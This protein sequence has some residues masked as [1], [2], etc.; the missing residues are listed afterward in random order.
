VQQI[1]LVVNLSC[2]KRF[3]ATGLHSGTWRL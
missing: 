1:A 3:G 2:F